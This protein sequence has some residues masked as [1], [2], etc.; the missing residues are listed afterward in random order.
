MGDESKY[1]LVNLFGG[2]GGCGCS[3][4]NKKGLRFLMLRCASKVQGSIEWM[5]ICC[6]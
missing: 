3:P 4:L 2:G 5:D 6:G 1:H